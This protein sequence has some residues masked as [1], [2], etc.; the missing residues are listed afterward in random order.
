MIEII[1]VVASADTIRQALGWQALR[2]LEDMVSPAWGG[3]TAHAGA[4]RP[5]PA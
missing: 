4:R 3:W 2:N 1:R 5:Q